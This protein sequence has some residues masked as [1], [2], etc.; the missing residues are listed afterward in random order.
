MW[1]LTFWLQSLNKCHGLFSI[2]GEQVINKPSDINNY[3]QLFCSS[4]SE[5][6]V[7]IVALR[8]SP[9]MFK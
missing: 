5:Y 8:N 7:S 4:Q 2:R 3:S 1:R 9:V 6:S